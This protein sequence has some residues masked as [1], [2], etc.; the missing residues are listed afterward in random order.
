MNREIVESSKVSTLPEV[1]DAK[2]E[3]VK[4]GSKVASRSDKIESEMDENKS[5]EIKENKCESEVNESSVKLGMVKNKFGAKIGKFTKNRSAK[6]VVRK[7]PK[8]SGHDVKLCE[9]DSKVV[10]LVNQ[11]AELEP[12]SISG[13]SLVNQKL[14]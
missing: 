6:T 2:I 8:T 13:K 9:S 5:C 14:V 7:V 11:S 3:R 4:E 1:L 12:K 10:E